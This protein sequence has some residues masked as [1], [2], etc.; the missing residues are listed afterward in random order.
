MMVRAAMNIC[1]SMYCMG[2]VCCAKK[3]HHTASHAA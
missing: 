2:M 1:L 3:H